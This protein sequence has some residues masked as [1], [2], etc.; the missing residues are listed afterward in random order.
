MLD[1]TTVTN[2]EKSIER[3]KKKECTGR[4]PKTLN[5]LSTNL[6]ESWKQLL[7][8]DAA[9]SFILEFVV[10]Y[11]ETKAII[12]IDKILTDILMKKINEKLTIFVD[13]TFAITPKLQ[14][15]NCQLWTIIIKYNNRV[16]KT[17][18]SFIH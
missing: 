1:F 14:N 16:S 10:K 17:I 6:K 2:I 5:D 7:Q 13:G 12:F 4:I 3:Y 8:I 15:T 18:N 11:N 9:D